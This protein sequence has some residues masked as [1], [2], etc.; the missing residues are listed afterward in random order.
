MAEGIVP[1]ALIGNDFQAGA[2][3]TKALSRAVSTTSMERQDG[4]NMH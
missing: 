4:T 1:S 2:T 3:V